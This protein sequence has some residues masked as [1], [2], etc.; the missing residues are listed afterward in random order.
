ML[1]RQ[2]QHHPCPHTRQALYRYPVSPS[3]GDSYAL[4]NILHSVTLALIGGALYFAQQLRGDTHAVVLHAE[5]QV[6]FV[7]ARGYGYFT[8][9]RPARPYSVLELI[10]NYGLKQHIQ[11]AQI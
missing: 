5:H 4:P 3:I 2:C 7:K 1:R 11:Y 6:V 8:G 9:L 10:F